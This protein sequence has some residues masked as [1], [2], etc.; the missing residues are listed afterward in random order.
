MTENFIDER[1]SLLESIKGVGRYTAAGILMEVEDINRFRKASK[2]S[3]YFGV[4][5]VFKISGDGGY[6][7]R[8]S[9]KGRS[10]WRSLLFM[11]ARNVVNHN[12]YFKD[13]YA[14]QRAKGMNDTAA[15]GVIMHKLTRT[16]F[17]ILKTK[18]AFDSKVDI[19]NQH[20]AIAQQTF[21]VTKQQLDEDKKELEMIIDAPVSGRKVNKKKKE[22]FASILTMEEHTRS[23]ALSSNKHNKNV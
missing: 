15:I 11:A 17:G 22:L 3:S 12:P 20:R 13:I 9:K 4:H 14:N 1:L 5:P 16:I 10:S 6:K 19:K 2:M 7:A 21:E 8:M 23:E 18:K